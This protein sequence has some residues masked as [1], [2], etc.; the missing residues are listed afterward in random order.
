MKLA[1]RIIRRGLIAI[2]L[3][4]LFLTIIEWR[5]GQYVCDGVTR[6]KTMS[7]ANTSMYR[8]RFALE[9]EKNVVKFSAGRR[10]HRDRRPNEDER[11]ATLGA[12][13][14][15]WQL[16]TEPY[17]EQ[18][19]IEFSIFSYVD[20]RTA[21]DSLHASAPHWLLA[22]VFGWLPASW[23]IRWIMRVRRGQR[24]RSAA[25][26]EHVGATIAPVAKP[27]LLIGR[28]LR[29]LMY[30]SI[31]SCL[32]L[33]L[34]WCQAGGPRD[35]FHFTRNIESLQFSNDHEILLQ[36]DGQGIEFRI[37][38]DEDFAP[39]AHSE[40]WYSNHYSQRL[41]SAS[42]AQWNDDSHMERFAFTNRHSRTANTARTDFAVL[43]P[44]RIAVAVAAVWPAIACLLAL[45]R[46]L[47]AAGRRRHGRCVLCGYDLRGSPERC[48]ECGTAS[49]KTTLSAGALKVRQGR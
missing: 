35:V 41:F 45:R 2:S 15:H 4:L 39:V 29:G 18:Y 30:L 38:A 27:G 6:S 48:P 5:R 10:S 3:L 25:N 20:E 49:R 14:W 40:Q 7:T 8:S 37:M 16:S 44:H 19:R 26:N 23:C 1:W 11:A 33:A 36:S 47:R 21:I 43:L 12:P 32:F 22:I 9:F 24:E 31:A 28:A 34:L 13:V 42:D 46:S 17:E